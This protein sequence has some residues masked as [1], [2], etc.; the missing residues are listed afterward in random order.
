MPEL[1]AGEAWAIVDEQFPYAGRCGFCGFHD[2]R[3]RI[4]DSVI[5]M[6]RAGDSYETL[7]EY[8]DVD[9]VVISALVVCYPLPLWCGS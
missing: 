1:K 5:S 7:A 6:N 8:Y 4:F 9:L 2:R 3:H